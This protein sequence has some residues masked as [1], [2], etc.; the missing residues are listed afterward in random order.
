MLTI[1]HRAFSNTAA[2]L[3]EIASSHEFIALAGHLRWQRHKSQGNRAEFFRAAAEAD[4]RVSEVRRQAAGQMA[5]VASVIGQ[6]AEALRTIEL[7]LDSLIARTDA[8]TQN[9]PEFA[10]LLRELQAMGTAIDWACAA[11]ISVICTGQRPTASSLADF[12]MASA[13]EIHEIVL[14]DAPPDVRALAAQFPDARLLPSSDGVVLAFGDIDTSPAVTTLVPGVGSANPASWDSYAA[15]ARTISAATGGAAVLWID[16]RAPSNVLG[17]TASNPA[18]VGGARL[19]DFQAELRRRA[20]RLGNEP[21]L[22]VFAHSYGSVVAGHA[23]KPGLNADALIVAGSPGVG[24]EH[25]S[26]LILRGEFPRVIAVTSPSDPIGLTTAAASGVHGPDPADPA[27]GAEVWPASGGH[28]S[29]WEDP[30]LLQNLRELR[31][32]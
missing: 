25:A 5:A 28:S 31:R 22:S 32:S 27:F 1:D 10:G 15:R 20:A 24:T 13:Q 2:E 23:A 11:E 8:A 9:S 16:Y 3:H 12:P 19:A 30:R 21:H 17:A 18:A 14:S 7:N 4:A 29:Y 26:G 6:A